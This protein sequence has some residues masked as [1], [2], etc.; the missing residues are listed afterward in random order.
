MDSLSA[1]LRARALLDTL[2]PREKKVLS[3][4][5]TVLPDV[6]SLKCFRSAGRWHNRSPFF[7]I[8]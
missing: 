5:M 7:P 4:I 2:T 6:I 8:A 3:P 1:V